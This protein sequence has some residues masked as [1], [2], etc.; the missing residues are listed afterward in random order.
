MATESIF[1][2]VAS[3]LAT[4]DIGKC[5]DEHGNT[6]EPTYDYFP[7]LISC[8][9]DFCCSGVLRYVPG[10]R[11]R[12]NALLPR[13][14]A[15]LRRPFRRQAVRNSCETPIASIILLLYF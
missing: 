15:R 8:V 3:V 12:S 14:R 2:S 13:A 1:I 4:L 5:I 10:R 11:C 6:I 9:N 7:G